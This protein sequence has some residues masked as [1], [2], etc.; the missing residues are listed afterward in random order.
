M[1]RIIKEIYNISFDLKSIPDDYKDSMAGG[2]SDLLN[3]TYE[4]LII[5]DVMRM[6]IQKNF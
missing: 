6:I 4:Q 1:N 5:F 2:Y 3:K